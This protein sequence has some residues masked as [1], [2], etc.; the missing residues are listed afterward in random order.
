MYIHDGITEDLSTNIT[1]GCCIGTANINNG[2]TISFNANFP[3]FANKHDMEV[4]FTSRGSV[5]NALNCGTSVYDS[6]TDN[7]D[8]PTFYQTWQQELWERI[9]NTHASG[10]GSYGSGTTMND[11]VDDVPWISL[12]SLMDYALSLLDTY[13]K[14]IDDILNGIYD[15]NE[16]IPD[17]YSEAWEDTIADCWDDVVDESEVS[18]ESG[19]EEPSDKEEPPRKEEDD[20][21]N[22]WYNEDGS[23]NPP[24]NNGAVLG[25]EETITLKPGDVVGRYG[26]TG[27]KSDFVTQPGTD[28]D[29][30]SLPPETKTSIY[31]EYIVSKYIFNV[32]KS[33]AAPWGGSSGG[34]IQYQLPVPIQELLDQEFLNKL[35]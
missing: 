13:Q 23:W 12:E 29:T 5:I 7:S 21:S 20:E 25:T 15:S 3:V 19:K 33:K 27:P 32:I 28:P 9:A 1:K 22:S 2:D 6:I 10:I 17:T 31:Q 26:E 4:Y 8:L 16:D 11:W 14:L 18:D 30:L 34:G 35:N 24:P